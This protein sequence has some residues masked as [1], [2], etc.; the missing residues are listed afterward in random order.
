MTFY[1]VSLSFWFYFQIDKE[2]AFLFYS[3]FHFRLFQDISSLLLPPFPIILEI[4]FDITFHFRALSFH[5]PCI[6]SFDT[7]SFHCRDDFLILI[8]PIYILR[9]ILPFIFWFFQLR[10]FHYFLLLFSSFPFTFHYS[11]VSN[12]WGRFLYLILLFLLRL[13]SGKP[14]FFFCFSSLF[15]PYAWLFRFSRYKILPL[16]CL[17]SPLLPLPSLKTL[18]SRNHFLI[19]YFA[20]REEYE[21]L[22]FHFRDIDF[23][24][25]RYHVNSF[26]IAFSSIL[27]S[28]L[29]YFLIFHFYRL[30]PLLK[31]T[32]DGKMPGW[33][34]YICVRASASALYRVNASIR[35]GIY[36][37]I[38][39]WWDFLSL[40]AFEVAFILTIS[41]VD[42][43]TG[44]VFSYSLPLDAASYNFDLAALFHL[45]MIYFSSFILFL[46]D[47]AILTAFLNFKIYSCR[48]VSI[49]FFF[50]E[51]FLV[52][53]RIV[54]TYTHHAFIL[55]LPALFC[56]IYFRSS[57]HFFFF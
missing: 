9:F 50:W 22:L 44:I 46:F 20:V 45:M 47:A 10:H 34:N 42:I 36:F 21:R 38:Y 29:R 8:L 6:I 33:L 51:I 27:Y 41:T 57:F 52:R 16:R 25:T 18:L 31:G 3:H 48:H 24:Y 2:W 49:H 13:I 14:T 43:P 30:Y 28:L 37:L 23:L 54:R 55:W 40:L 15:A 32:N 11:F 12:A 19:Y 56:F 17:I 39:F 26:I 53:V 35:W 1:F 4:Y 7:L 5:F